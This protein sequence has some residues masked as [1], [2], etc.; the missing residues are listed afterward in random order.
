MINPWL[1]KIRYLHT[2]TNTWNFASIIDA[3]L[4]AFILHLICRFSLFFCILVITFNPFLWR[5]FQPVLLLRKRIFIL[6]MITFLQRLHIP[7]SSV[8]GLSQHHIR[9]VLLQRSTFNFSI[10]VTNAFHLSKLRLNVISSWFVH[11]FKNKVN[12]FTKAKSGASFVHTIW[13][14]VKFI[15][16]KSD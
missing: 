15:R 8:S 14:I 2:K 13:E 11:L 10:E 7:K 12:F 9:V 3:F 4:S 16:R 5:C 6:P 1:P